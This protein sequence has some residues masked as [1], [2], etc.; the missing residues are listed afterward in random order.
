MRS[1]AAIGLFVLSRHTETQVIAFFGLLG[2]ANLAARVVLSRLGHI[3]SCFF[4]PPDYTHSKLAAS[5]GMLVA[6]AGFLPTTQSRL[7]QT[8]FLLLAVLAIVQGARMVFL[9][10]VSAS[11]RYGL[12]SAFRS[13][14]SPRLGLALAYVLVAGNGAFSAKVLGAW[15]LQLSETLWSTREQDSYA[16]A[17]VQTGGGGPPQGWLGFGTELRAVAGMERYRW[18]SKRSLAA[19][20]P[21]AEVDRARSAERDYIIEHAAGTIAI[22]QRGSPWRAMQG[23]TREEEGEGR[24]Q[25]A[26]I[27]Q[28]S[29]ILRSLA[30]IGKPENLTPETDQRFHKLLHHS[31][32]P[33]ALLVPE[34]LIGYEESVDDD[35]R[36]RMRGY[37]LVSAPMQNVSRATPQVISLLANVALSLA[38]SDRR[39]DPEARAIVRRIAA[40]GLPPLADAY[41]RFRLSA[42]AVERFLCLFDCFE[43]LIKYSVFTVSALSGVAL[44]AALE[45]PSLGTWTNVL[46]GSL[47][48]KVPLEGDLSQSTAEFWHRSLGDKPLELI[49]AVNGTGLSWSGKV[50]RSHL[51][52]LEWLVW[53]RNKTK[54]H[55]GVEESACVPIWHEFHAVLLDSARQ[56]S[57]LVLE[58]VI[59]SEDR[60]GERVALRGWLRG[61]FRSSTIERD[62]ATLSPSNR[63]PRLTRGAVPIDL[64][65]FVHCEGNTC[66]TWN[67]GNSKRGEYIDYATGRLRRRKPYGAEGLTGEIASGT[68]AENRGSRL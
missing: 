54:G 50:P 10:L 15:L 8:A 18:F 47:T 46:R 7:W 21:L 42:S 68:D 6:V 49:D 4:C 28:R 22:C 9:A 30:A 36:D 67:S 11:A 25:A 66:L 39:L 27:I 62:P 1:L 13:G 20:L 44:L 35:G 63:R 65:P 57:P 19:F 60:Q 24:R 53:L 43:V 34:M 23:I 16:K 38:R 12:R 59:W 26:D 14:Q 55:G 5:A 64:G 32:G 48:G 37:E 51:G 56:L 45:R 58:S 41:L 33:V 52:W 3:N 29:T 40:D 2:G 17:Q 31:I 61:P